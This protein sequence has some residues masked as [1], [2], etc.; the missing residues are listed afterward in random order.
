[1]KITRSAGVTSATKPE[2]IPKSNAEWDSA[3]KHIKEAIDELTVPA[4]KGC[5]VSKDAIANLSVVLFDL[6]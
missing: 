3:K 2:N 4:S 6:K 1:M 5:E